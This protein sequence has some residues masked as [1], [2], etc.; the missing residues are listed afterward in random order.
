MEIVAIIIAGIVGLI[1]RLLKVKPLNAW[2]LGCVIVPV[3]V[4]FAEFVLSYQGGGAS[5]WPI[6]LVFGGA[7][8]AASSAG[9]VFIAGLIVKGSKNAT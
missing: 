8:G 7:Y 3:F 4:L 2:L 1:A 6:A 9:G 5:M